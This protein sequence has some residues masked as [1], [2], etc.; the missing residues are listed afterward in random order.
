MVGTRG[1]A[2]QQQVSRS[3]FV[4]ELSLT[5][6]LA[7]G[8]N[9]PTG[10]DTATVTFARKGP[11]EIHM[12]NLGHATAPVNV[13]CSQSRLPERDWT[14][15]EAQYPSLDANLAVC[16]DRTE[17]PFLHQASRKARHTTVRQHGAQL[18]GHGLPIRKPRNPRL[19]CRDA[20]MCIISQ[21]SNASPTSGLGFE[22]FSCLVSSGV[23]WR[24]VAAFC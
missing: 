14:T 13:A 24:Q 8:K 18:R 11:N 20:T 19:L 5:R 1:H 9:A 23:A 6:P 21:I 22:T 3:C 17:L 12:E 16:F 4:A 2:P 15:M 10:N 7:S